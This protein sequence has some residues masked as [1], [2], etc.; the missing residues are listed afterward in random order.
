MLCFNKCVACQTPKSGECH[1]RNLIRAV[2]CVHAMLTLLLVGDTRRRS[3]LFFHHKHTLYFSVK[4]VPASSLVGG[5]WEEAP[6]I[7]LPLQFVTQKL[8]SMF[9]SCLSLKNS[10]FTNFNRT[11]TS[12]AIIIAYTVCD[13]LAMFWLLIQLTLN[14]GILRSAYF[15]QRKVRLKQSL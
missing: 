3:L 8:M 1:T 2:L 12:V 15:M 10:G 5:I 7:N 6:K 13:N 14:R 11:A 9:Q 4:L